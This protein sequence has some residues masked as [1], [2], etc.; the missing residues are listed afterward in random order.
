M[1]QES[2]DDAYLALCVERARTQYLTWVEQFLDLLE[3]R[4]DGGRER[5]LNDIGCNLG[6]F[7]K[8]LARR[9]G[10]AIDY[11]GFDVEE[12]YRQ[13]AVKVFPELDGKLAGLDI[14]TETPPS[15]DV[16]VVS[17]TME[18]LPGLQPALGHLLD[19]TQ[20]IALI[21]TLMGDT[22][23]T[24]LRHKPGAAKP[25]PVNQYSFVE[26]LAAC[27]ES[28]FETEVHRDRHT[29]SLPV[30]LGDGIVRRQY[31]VVARR[32]A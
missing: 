16:T 4:I 14:T 1:F 7:W 17:A 22:S 10:L 9:D 26:L 28:G 13:E 20:E 3:E 12:I 11:R 2:Q 27:E 6:Q 24:A 15:A 32:A 30:Y 8:G 21:R 18:H 23:E 29:D 19:S 31:V 25:Y 5:T